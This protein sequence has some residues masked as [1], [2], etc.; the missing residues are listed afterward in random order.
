MNLWNVF[1]LLFILIIFA[2]TASASISISGEDARFDTG[3]SGVSISTPQSPVTS[4]FISSEDARTTDALSSVSIST[5]QSPVTSFFISGEDA[6]TTDALSSVSISTPQSPMTTFFISGEDA[7][8]SKPLFE[9]WSVGTDIVSPELFITYPSD[10]TII[11]SQIVTI[12]GTASDNNAIAS[13]TVNGMPAI[14][15][16]DWNAEVSLIEG[17]NIITIITKDLQNNKRTNK[18]TVHYY[19]LEDIHLLFSYP[20]EIELGGTFYKWYKTIPY[21]TISIDSNYLEYSQ[22]DETGIFSVLVNTSELGITTPG[23]LDIITNSISITKNGQTTQ[24]NTSTLNFALNILPRNYSTS[25][26][27]GST[28]GGATGVVA[29]GGADLDTD[30]KMTTGNRDSMLQMARDKSYEG[31]AGLTASAFESEAPVI[32]KVDVLKGNVHASNQI[33]YGSQINVDYENADDAQKLA[34]ALYV[35]TSTI[36]TLNPMTTRTI[37]T[38]SDALTSDLT[39]DYYESGVAFSGGSSANLF[40]FKIGS[41]TESTGVKVGSADI[42]LGIEAG[43]SFKDRTYPI[44]NYREYLIRYGYN[45]E[46]GASGS[47]LGN[48]IVDW[49]P[50]KYLDHTMIFGEDSNNVLYGK[51]K[52]KDDEKPVMLDYVTKEI[53]YDYGIIPDKIINPFETNNVDTSSVFSS[54]IDSIEDYSS[55]ANVTAYETRGKRTNLKPQLKITVLG[56]KLRLS[57]GISMSDANNYLIDKS[58]IVNQ[59]PYTLEKYTYDSQ[60]QGSAEELS[61]I[62]ESLLAPVGNLMESIISPITGIAEQGK[63][64]IFNTGNVIFD[65]NTYFAT[66]DQPIAASS[67]SSNSVS[68]QSPLNNQTPEITISTYASKEPAP[69]AMAALSSMGMSTSYAIS[70]SGG[71]FVIGNITDLQPYNISFTPAAQLT[72]N[73]TDTDIIGINESNISIYRWDD[74]NNSW[75]QLPS[76]V[77]LAG[78]NASTNITR[79]GTYTIGYDITTPIIEWNSSNIYQGNVTVEA[80]VT[81][82]GSGINTSSIQLYLD[83]Q[84]QIFTYNIFSGRLKSTINA[85]AGNH[86]VR[87]YAED[88]SGNSNITE[89]DVI[90]INSTYIQNLT[91]NHTNDTLDVSWI[92]EN[93]TYQIQYY[94]LYRDTE[95]ISNTTQTDITLKFTGSATYTVYPIDTNGNTGLG[96][97]ITYRFSQLVP[98]FTYNWENTLYP[99]VGNAITFDGDNSYLINGTVNATITSYTWIFDDDVNDTVSGKV[100]SHTFAD[101]GLH[102]IT[103]Q[104]EDDSLNNETLTKII[105]LKSVNGT[106]DFSG[107]GAT[108]AWDITYLAR[109]IAGISGYETLS[110]GDVSD[111]G[112]VDAWD[113]T[114]LARAIAGIIGYNV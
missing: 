26:Y 61:Y 58:I 108:D 55:Q 106:G 11:S 95:L 90:S 79:F 103:L 62:I 94:H 18:L 45:V 75:M 21:S 47:L 109:S 74:L 81:D 83:E 35:L 42:G 19:P 3:L 114:Y 43:C 88:T 111:D 67:I 22:P 40:D 4:F 41:E 33:M 25:W 8:T 53:T 82:S 56:T 104:I 101:P 91:I 9:S 59:K 100:I 85:S 38:V 48:D 17:E 15:T 57:G 6:R 52:I 37:D 93:G 10:G 14:G 87:I 13:V 39:T 80:F 51:L 1:T 60:V 12:S 50:S 102:K 97:S 71:N 65:G 72:L 73:Y 32:G 2:G 77:D 63:K 76:I 84:E 68:I 34:G 110:S 28:I 36:S 107:N 49:G 70:L 23:T 29:Y 89:K 16:T 105:N 24:G 5:P 64:L 99:N 69:Q 113:I 78:N 92:G 27:L 98:Q 96:K 112:K 7:I 54:F 30:F 66:I 20:S 46:G 86:S 44:D 31:T